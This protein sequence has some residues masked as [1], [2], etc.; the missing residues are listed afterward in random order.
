MPCLQ[1]WELG[2][3]GPHFTGSGQLQFLKPGTDPHAYP[4]ILAIQGP[5][6]TPPSP[7]AG[8]K[9]SEGVRGG[10]SAFLGSRGNPHCPGSLPPGCRVPLP[11]AARS[12]PCRGAGEGRPRPL[13]PGGREGTRGVQ[14]LCL[15][16]CVYVC[17]R[18]CETRRGVGPCARARAVTAAEMLDCPGWRG[19]GGEERGLPRPRPPTRELNGARGGGAGAFV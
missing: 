2:P 14:T 11:T 4:G 16:V 7:E 5:P 17:V 1:F 15:L 13:R 6:H 8:L 18:D 10:A 3:L 9:P 19:R 12:L